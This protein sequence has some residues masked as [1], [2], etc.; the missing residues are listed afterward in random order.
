MC[1]CNSELRRAMALAGQILS[2]KQNRYLDHTNA[3]QVDSNAFAPAVSSWARLCGF[4]LGTGPEAAKPLLR[5]AVSH[6]L[7]ASHLN[8]TASAFVVC[9]EAGAVSVFYGS[10]S[11]DPAQVF[12]SMIPDCE[13]C[14]V[15]SWFSDG[16]RYSGLFLGGVPADGAAEAV[17]SSG[18]DH[19]YAACLAVPVADSDLRELLEEDRRLVLQLSQY[20]TVP[21]V[22]GMASRRTVDVPVPQVA[23]ALEAVQNEV[24]LLEKARG[25]GVVQTVIRFGAGTVRHI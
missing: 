17:A 2:F 21:R 5:R 22:Y 23:E 20:K 3:I 6:W 13:V 4:R 9:R 7:R 10:G 18:L 11:I 15:P 24:S 16:Y 8:G 19:C 1:S 25:V 12:Q 14:S